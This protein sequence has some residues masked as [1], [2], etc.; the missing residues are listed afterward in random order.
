MHTRYGPLPSAPPP[1]DP[2]PIQG[3]QCIMCHYPATDARTFPCGCV[4]SIHERCVPTFRAI[5]GICPRC[6]Q[7]WIPV[8]LDDRSEYTVIAQRESKTH[9]MCFPHDTWRARVCYSLCC[10]LL[11]GGIVLCGFLLIKVYG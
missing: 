6:K 1:L 10:V 2:I 3:Y 5:G 9:V 11:V 7:V 8:V 4:Y